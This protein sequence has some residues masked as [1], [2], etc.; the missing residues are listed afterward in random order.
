MPFDSLRVTVRT[1]GGTLLEV[2]GVRW[3]QAQLA[4]GGGIGIYPGHAPLLA[5]TVAAQVRYLT[6]DGEHGLPLE[7]GILQVSPGA[8]SIH[9]TGL[10]SGLA[11]GYEK[12]TDDG[13]LDR[14]AHAVLKALQTE[15]AQVPDRQASQA[16]SGQDPGDVQET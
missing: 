10:A 11:A 15:R 2:D 16:G 7:A 9:T 4:D 12:P 5:E 6:G 8:V 1:P 3:V 13:R 14:L